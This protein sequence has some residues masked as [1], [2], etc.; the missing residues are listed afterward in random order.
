METIPGHINRFYRTLS[1]ILS[2]GEIVSSA[3]VIAYYILFSI[4]PIIIIVG[5]V[6]PLFRINTAPIAEYLRL[7]FPEQIAVYIMPIVNSLLKTNSNGYISFGI[8]LA[9]W[10][11]SNLVNAIRIGMN[12]LYDV[13]R[14]E[15][16]LS[17]LSFLWNRSATIFL[18]ALMIF[19][20]NGIGLA[21]I[22]GQQILDFVQ[23]IFGF[24]FYRLKSILSYRY[25]VV[26]VIMLIA[27]AYLNYVLPNIKLKKRK[28][29]P[30]VF[31]TVLGW[32]ILSFGFSFYLHNFPISWENY[33]IIGTFIIFMLWLYL[34]AM[35]L[36][37]G[38]SI[39][40]TI[41]R[42]KY[43]SVE[44]SSGRLASYIQ[45]KRRQKNK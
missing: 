31:V 42:L 36:L 10:S 16:K 12:R 9:V 14:I 8:I 24:S 15:L 34:A 2:E 41:V 21:F 28:I 38:T 32:I 18:T 37:F 20:F 3:I 44:F 26:I 1:G 6:L 22:F 17:F 30:G 25:P 5:N 39:N 27:V 35:M 23:Q 19:V 29:W 33:G 11:F 7:I 40:A 45:Q 13:H 43:G 4:F